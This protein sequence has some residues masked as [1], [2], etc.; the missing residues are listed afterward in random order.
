MHCVWYYSSPRPAAGASAGGGQAV[1]GVAAEAAIGFL[2]CRNHPS[3]VNSP[4]FVITAPGCCLCPPAPQ[5]V[6]ELC[7]EWQPEPLEGALSEVQR[8]Q[9]R[10]PV[11]SRCAP[12]SFPHGRSRHCGLDAPSRPVL[13]LGRWWELGRGP[14]WRHLAPSAGCFRD[15]VAQVGGGWGPV[16]WSPEG[17]GVG[18]HSWGG[19]CCGGR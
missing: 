4:S 9:L 17:G 6:D 10:T 19:N 11:L 13:T 3:P 7:R 5:E 18:G 8:L 14:G 16:C 2:I 15:D 1:Q 12:G